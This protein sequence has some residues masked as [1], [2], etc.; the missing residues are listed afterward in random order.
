[1]VSTP[2]NIPKDSNTGEE[3][4]PNNFQP[5]GNTQT[6]LQGS[7]ENAEKSK[8]RLP[9]D[10][11][12]IYITYEGEFKLNQVHGNGVLTIPGKSKFEG[13][14]HQ[15]IKHGK[16]VY[17]NYQKG[18]EYNGDY[19]GGRRQG[20]G[21]LK[22]KDGSLYVGDF[23]EGKK[24]GQGKVQ[25]TN[26]NWYNGNWEKGKKHGK[27]IMHWITRNEKYEGDWK[28]N[29]PDGVGTHI[30]LEKKKTHQILR[31]RYE[32]EF[33]NGLR[34]G[35]GVFYYANGARYEGEWFQNMKHG[36]ACYIDDN[37][38]ATYSFFQNNK[39][40]QEIEVEK[41][42][43]SSLI[44]QDKIDKGILQ[45]NTDRSKT[46]EKS[47]FAMMANNK[48]DYQKLKPKS[49]KSKTKMSSKILRIP[50][51]G[52]RAIDS[53]PLGKNG[54]QSLTLPKE[55]SKSR[56]A[57]NSLANSRQSKS[58]KGSTIQESSVSPS[59]NDLK[60]SS[61]FR[62]SVAVIGSSQKLSDNVIRRMSITASQNHLQNINS[63]EPSLEK[64]PTNMGNLGETTKIELQSTF[65]IFKQNNI[66][67]EMIE[68]DSILLDASQ[69]HKDFE[70]YFQ[71]QEKGQNEE[72]EN[73]LGHSL[74][75]DNKVKQKIKVQVCEVLLR[76]HSNLK[77]WYRELAASVTPGYEEGFFL[78]FQT[79]FQILIDTRM[80]N[81]RLTLASLC[82][83][84]KEH[85]WNYSS[86]QMLNV[87]FDKKHVFYQFY[88]AK[89]KAHKHQIGISSTN[90]DSKFKKKF[91]ASGQ[92]INSYTEVTE[93]N[94]TK[95]GGNDPSS[96][97][98]GSSEF[99]KPNLRDYFLEKYSSLIL[100]SKCIEEVN[101]PLLF[102]DFINCLLMAV[103][104]KSGSIQGLAGYFNNYMKKRFLPIMGKV[105]RPKILMGDETTILR[106]GKLALSAND[107]KWRK[108]IQKIWT[109]LSSR[110]GSQDKE[111]S[112]LTKAGNSQSG[113]IESSS[114][115]NNRPLFGKLGS[116]KS[117][118]D[119][120][121]FLDAMIGSNQIKYSS[122]EDQKLVWM[123]LERQEDPEE[124][125][126]RLLMKIEK[127]N[128]RTHEQIESRI[129]KWIRI[130][131]QAEMTYNEFENHFLVYFCK[132]NNINAK[133]S[134]F[135]RKFPNF[136]EVYVPR[137]IQAAENVNGK[138]KKSARHFPIT[139][140]DKE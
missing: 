17:I 20:Q 70:N 45:I 121:S 86:K 60:N 101:P 4:H 37:E 87:K 73:D 67:Y 69:V 30:W 77:K 21:T 83:Y 124:S 120:K 88:L 98:I 2:A 131:L 136:L 133:H 9:L 97:L 68:L 106:R 61:T 93:E 53:S 23:L 129:L 11:N 57:R 36:Y 78:D 134:T 109:I 102:S 56:S 19:F 8:P 10:P 27:G 75:G 44:E 103:H 42:L 107:E 85:V 5:R 26:G 72:M 13:S 119:V 34:H 35:Y 59:R 84:L 91:E 12:I 138:R 3:Q 76:H 25:W 55:R 96:Q 41:D 15:G 32:G 24:H 90:L 135:K 126:F 140:K 110:P 40:I 48:S 137:I 6:S 111:N 16:G 94:S 33:L 139:Q 127:R 118:I 117:G 29:K 63:L 14:F 95:Q 74:L 125:L 104:I 66:Y 62:N 1:M 54:P 49:I 130:K 46:L 58:K 7:V 81:G 22:L 50:K 71:E 115:S 92:K 18:V 52:D 132:L 47:S 89:I 82:R 122:I 128:G 51:H 112:R 123:T 113:G 99:L 38:N 79:F 105:I 116:Y 43:M 100:E 65:D 28:N 64:D 31:N 39:A 80:V 108:E 114:A